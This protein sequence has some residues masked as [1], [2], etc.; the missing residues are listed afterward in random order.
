[1]NLGSLVPGCR[2]DSSTQIIVD[3]ISLGST[4]FGYVMLG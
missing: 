2:S 4:M 3:I 1:M